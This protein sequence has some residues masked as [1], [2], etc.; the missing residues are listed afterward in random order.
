MRRLPVLA[1]LSAGLL[2]S[3]LVVAAPAQA[4]AVT[5]VT[6]VTVPA[7]KVDLEVSPGA[8]LRAHL[9]DPV[10]VSPGD[11]VESILYTTYIAINT[12]GGPVG[13]GYLQMGHL[14]GG[15]PQDGDWEFQ[16]FDRARAFGNWE[17][18]R[19]HVV[20]L[21]GT[22]ADIPLRPLGFSTVFSTL[23]RFT[24]EIDHQSP[25]ITQTTTLGYGGSI[26]LRGRLSWHELNAVHT[27][28]IKKVTVLQE[29][30]DE[31]VID[32]DERVL[33]TTTTGWDGTFSV[34]VK[35][36]RHA[37]RIYLTTTK[38]TLVN[39]VRYTDAITWIAR[40]DVKFRIGLRSKPTSLKAG[41][42]GYVEGSVAPATAG[43]NAYLQR[44]KGG[45]WTIVSSASVRSSG[46]FT[47]A[48]QPPGKGSF[49]YR[50]YKPSDAGHVYNYT[51]EFTVQG[52]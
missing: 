19:I 5:Q 16:P 28:P 7:T 35:P 39:G 8:V 26:T 6:S 27:I 33:T 18:N 4:A 40:V 13:G 12:Q 31:P 3:G 50:V 45:K 46:R 25:A 23:G 1:V 2:T 38:G 48:A 10:G 47:L 34:T 14:V 24:A 42:I 41:T 32:G 36:D 51:P 44:Y 37:F 30:Q 49:R 43:Q 52:I 9:V 11:P 20:R 15:T 21:D 17:A 29:D 22:Q